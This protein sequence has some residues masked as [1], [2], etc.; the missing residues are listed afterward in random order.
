MHRTPIFSDARPQIAGRG[1]SPGCEDFDGLPLNIPGLK[2]ASRDEATDEIHTAWN[3][4]TM[5][6]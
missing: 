3:A 6:Y 2:Y 1:K 5:R 4:N